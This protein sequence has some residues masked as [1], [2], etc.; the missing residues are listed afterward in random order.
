MERHQS[1]KYLT[2]AAGYTKGGPCRALYR[3]SDLPESWKRQADLHA[4]AW[5]ELRKKYMRPPG[6]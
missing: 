3:I 4:K 1:N 5:K 6:L 2:N